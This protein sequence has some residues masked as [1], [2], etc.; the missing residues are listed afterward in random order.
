MIVINEWEGK[1]KQDLWTAPNPQS[2]KELKLICLPK[3]GL[4]GH[5]A[6]RKGLGI[7]SCSEFTQERRSCGSE[8]P[9]TQLFL[10]SQSQDPAL[11]GPVETS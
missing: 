10:A 8:P 1:K 4:H 9:G 6:V 7:L 3:G 2:T 5:C 11:T